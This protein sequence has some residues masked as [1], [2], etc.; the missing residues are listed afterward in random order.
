MMRFK[1]SN[2][3]SIGNDFYTKLRDEALTKAYQTKNYEN[4]SQEE[5]NK[6]YDNILE[7]LKQERSETTMKYI[8]GFARDEFLQYMYSEFPSVYNNAHSRELLENTVDYC[9][10]INKKNEG[11]LIDKLESLIP[12]VTHNEITRYFD[13]KP[14][15]KVIITSL[16]ELK[17]E[18]ESLDWSIS[19]C[20]FSNGEI[21]WDIAQY[22]PAGEDF[23]FSICHNNDVEK[24]IKEIDDYAYD[25]FDID[26]HI[27]MWIEARNVENNRMGVPSPC[28]LVEDANDI[29]EMLYT[30][31]NHCNNL[32]IELNKETEP[33]IC[34][35]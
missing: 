34:D 28:E 19:D 25:C 8:N 15:E 13:N 35:N 22:S 21:G 3:F 14:K 31:A 7:K 24:A 20:D 23:S 9:I 29:Q 18:I 2:V 32:D 12:E 10:E 33:D 6:I 5:R 1:E 16:E 26:E 27:S 11:K 4:L 17:E 30:L